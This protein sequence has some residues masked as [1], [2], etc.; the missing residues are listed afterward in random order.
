MKAILRPGLGGEPGDSAPARRRARRPAPGAAAPRRRRRATSRR[1]ASPRGR[2]VSP[3]RSAQLIRPS[4]AR[5][6]LGV[7]LGAHERTAPPLRPRPA[8]PAPRPRRPRLRRAGFLKRRAAE[9]IVER[10]EAI[11]QRAFPIAVDLGA[12]DGA[13]AAAL[14]AS[15]A[16]RQG[17]PADRDRPLRSACWPAGPARA[18]SLD[19]ERLPFA[20]DSLDLVVSSLALH[21]TNDLV[22]AL[23]QIR[24]ALKPDGLFLG[25]ILGGAT[26][27]E[28]RAR[29]D[30]RRAGGARRRRPARLAVRRRL[31]RRGPAAARRASPCRWPTSTASTVRYDHRCTLMADL[32]AM[33]ETSVLVEGAGRPL[34]PRAC[35]PAPPSSTPSASPGRTGASPPPSRS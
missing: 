29:A 7:A 18:W 20:P 4:L 26:L 11:L 9:D 23:I 24:Q 3:P 6:R 22:G 31:R 32:R 28:L 25:A 14:A 13:F 16:A 34:T 19:E 5:A 33:G 10:L 15:D 1:R 12:R 17:R 21:W 30:R 8:P 2:P 35:W 27:I